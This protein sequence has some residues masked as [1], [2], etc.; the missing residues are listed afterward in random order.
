MNGFT[1]LEV[2]V[3]LV[4]AA[5]LSVAFSHAVGTGL[6]SSRESSLYRAAIVRARS[7]L[8]AATYGT[9]LA[10]GQSSGEDGGGFRWRTAVTPIRTME[11]RPI[12][13]QGRSDIPSFPVVLYGITA[14][15]VW[16]EGPHERSVRLGTQQIGG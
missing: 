9:R 15:E 1:L 7:H 5:L 4:I 11:V 8:A 3:A 13:A 10:E 2:V 14:W 6:G 12:G 16:S